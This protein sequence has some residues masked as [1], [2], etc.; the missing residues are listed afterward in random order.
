M[1]EWASEK[2]FTRLNAK[3]RDTREDAKC[4]RDAKKE[5]VHSMRI[6]TCIEHE[7]TLYG[8]RADLNFNCLGP[9]RQI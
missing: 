8:V 6:F 4:V 3:K 5:C 1:L 2:K 9:W 7:M